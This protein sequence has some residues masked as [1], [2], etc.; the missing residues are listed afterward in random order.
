M[1][2]YHFILD[3][4]LILLFTKVLGLLTRKIKLPQ[5]VGAIIAGVL[6][7]PAMLGLIK[8]TDFI[9]D[10]SKLGVIVIMYEAG[11]NTDI[12]KLKKAGKTSF[13]IALFGVIVPIAAGFGLA[14]LFTSSGWID[15]SHSTASP[16]LQNML[17]GVVLSATS[18]SIT[19]EALSEMGKLSTEVGS[20]ILGAAIIDDVLG[21]VALTIVT[22]FVDPDINIL[23]VLLK[24]VAFFVLAGVLA[25]AYHCF[26]KK[27][28]SHYGKKKRRFVITSFVFCLFLAYIA[29]KYFGVADITGA[30]VAGLAVSR[31][32]QCDYLDHRFSTLSY[33]L[34]SP[35][36]FASIGLKVSLPSVN[37]SLLIFSVCFIV[38]AILCKIIGCGFASKIMGL[39]NKDS[40]RVGVGMITRGEVALIIANKGA[41]LGI[42]DNV[43]FAPI[44]LTV[45]ITAITTPIFLKLAFHEKTN[46]PISGKI[47]KKSKACT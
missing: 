4:A 16:F 41:A 18:V 10:L 26:F 9:N 20:T 19:V 12:N 22:S 15:A 42:M 47:D 7:G 14:Q 24:I 32:Q 21:L 25:F 23:I 29:E 1:E 30:F 44:V 17:I 43:F 35:V 46:I 39:D 37:T 3:L 28:E 13:V 11:L 6:L 31:T 45:I 5:V 40:L 34:L 2:S 38:V 36:F 33:M 27:W 8:G